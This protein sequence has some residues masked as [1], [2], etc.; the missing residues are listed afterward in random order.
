MSIASPDKTPLVDGI[1]IVL[2][3]ELISAFR[4][5]GLPPGELRARDTTGKLERIGRDDLPSGLV[6][7][8]YTP[9]A[10]VVSAAV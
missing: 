3:Y 6:Q 10:E 7:L 4:W 2:D 5:M 1:K 8:I 9:E